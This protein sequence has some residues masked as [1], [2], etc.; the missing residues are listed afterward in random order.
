ME[1]SIAKPPKQP[2]LILVAVCSLLLFSCFVP[3]QTAVAPSPEEEWVAHPMNIVAFNGESPAGYTPEQIKA[4]YNLPESGGAGV[5][6]AV[7]IAY[8]TPNI[9][10]YLEV[11]SSEFGLPLPTPDNFEVHK[12]AD[13]ISV[14]DH[15]SREACLDVQW[16]HAIAPQAK[17]LLVEATSASA[18][19]LLNAINYAKNRP[20]VDVISMSWGAPETLATATWDAALNCQDITLFASTGDSGAEVNW[21]A[22]SPHVVAVGGTTLTL[23]S[24][25]VV[26][27]ETGWSGSGGGVSVV[28]DQPN[29]QA[30]YGL[31][32]AKRTIPDVSYNA[33]PATGV[34]VYNN[35]TW[36]KLGGTS[37]GAPQ[38]AAIYALNLSVTHQNLYGKAASAYSS[39]FRDVTTGSNGYS[40]TVGYDYVTGLGSP[41]TID[42]GSFELSPTSGPAE[43]TVTL[44]GVGF[45]AGSSVDIEYLNPI[46]DTWVTVVSG[47][48]TATEN[49]RYITTAPDLLGNNPAGDHP[50]QIDRIIYRATDNANSHQYNTSLPYQE[51]RRGITEVGITQATGVFGNNTDLSEA[52]FVENSQFVTVTGENFKAGTATLW[53]DDSVDLGTTPIDADGSFSASIEVPQ[54][55]AAGQ[56]TVTVNDGACAFCVTLSRT[57]IVSDDSTD[58]WYTSDLTV[59]LEADFTGTQI[60]YKINEGA[61]KTVAADG[62][63]LIQSEDSGNTLEYWGVWDIYGSGSM[64]LDHVTLTDIKLDKTAPSGSI[65]TASPTSTPSITLSLD[66]S[67]ATS[68]VADMHF[69]NDGSSYTDWESY[70]ATKVWTLTGGDGSKN[71]YVQYRDHAGLTATCSCTVTLGSSDPDPTPPPAAT[72]TPTPTETPTPTPTATSTE[73]P[74]T[75]PFDGGGEPSVLPETSQ[76]LL[77]AAVFGALLLLLVFKK[78]E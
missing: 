76:I 39:Y 49:F 40:A 42:Y 69:S 27:S 64:E 51:P 45:T 18:T 20:D 8:D 30:D 32:N 10:S 71:V 19:P 33:D 62:Q 13:T 7:I 3:A 34:P 60:Y 46:T 68:G 22:V 63:P 75:T 43:G 57:P 50:A 15:W 72:P 2:R 1:R 36:L 23:D 58:M 9:T 28:Y 4:A 53:W 70:A 54:S 25:N 74:E 77:I 41:L 21:P 24:S 66:A 65:W 14:D 29:Y 48:S 61:T 59:N 52:A 78:K 47:L 44:R 6:I 73:E 37:M 55:A 16:A 31:A 67:D 12:M 26:T 38:W 56:H 11:F 5:T 17:I 35:G